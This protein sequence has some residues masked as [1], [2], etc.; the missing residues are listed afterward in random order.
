M[1]DFSEQPSSARHLIRDGTTV[2]LRDLLSRLP[3][4]SVDLID[5]SDGGFG[6]LLPPDLHVSVGD[7]FEFQIPSRDG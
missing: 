3:S 2:L 7:Q 4:L 6:C 5:L 1:K